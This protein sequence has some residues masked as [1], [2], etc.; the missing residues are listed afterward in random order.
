MIAEINRIREDMRN[1]PTFEGL[2]PPYSTITVNIVHGGV[3][4]NIVAENCEF[5]WEMRIIP[6]RAIW[7]SS[8]ACSVSQQKSSSRR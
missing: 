2:D 4:G 8:S 7:P 5:I 6:A 1:G 3:A